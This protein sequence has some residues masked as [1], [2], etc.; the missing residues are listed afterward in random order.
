M[1]PRGQRKFPKSWRA[2]L[3]CTL[4]VTAT[5]GGPLTYAKSAAQSTTTAV[6]QVDAG[7]KLGTISPVAIGMNT[8]VWDAHLQDPEIPGLLRALKIKILRFPGGITSDQYH[9]QTNSITP[10]QN[11]YANPVNT[12]DNFMHNVAQPLGAQVMIDVNYGSNLT[13]DGGGSPAEAAA[14]VKYA[15]ITRKYGVKYWAIGNEVYG[16]GYYAT[17]WETD[18]HPDHS[19][20]AYGKNS[21]AFIRAMKAVDPTIKVGVVLA[22]PDTWPAAWVDDWNRKV[23]SIVGKQI[24]FVDIHWYP[25]TPGQ[26]SDAG[27]LATTRDVP[28]IV[29]QLRSLIRQYCGNHAARVQIMLTE[30]NSVSYNPGKQ[31]VSLVSALFLADDVMTW[32]ENGIANVDW[33]TL[34][35]P[36]TVGYNNS[37]SLYGDAQYGD[38]GILSSG[39]FQNGVAEPPVNTPFPTYYGL[40]MLSYL[41]TSGDTM[42]AS[43]SNNPLL[44]VHSVKQSNGRLAVLFINKDP[45]R[46]IQTDVSLR[47]FTPC[48]QGTLYLYGKGS[49]KIATRN[50]TGAGG[51]FRISLP[52][53]AL[54]TV[55][56]SPKP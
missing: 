24:D 1:I 30:T 23:L 29:A 27:L 34:H 52:P 5:A 32:L 16:N 26:E 54:V 22:T 7:K 41:G 3:L 51:R 53:Y 56:M 25:E 6:V 55:V 9:W 15:N 44:A 12:F 50:W 49:T 2:A 43:S 10:G 37:A 20:T 19:P 18:L 17:P 36:M 8:A 39:D 14:W 40:Q 4:A 31:T 48:A 42:V 47:G 35:V 28:H 21:L 38:E 13:G 33:W 45:A 46:T 11:S